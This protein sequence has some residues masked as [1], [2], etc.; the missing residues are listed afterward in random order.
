MSTRLVY[1]YDSSILPWHANPQAIQ[2]ILT[3]LAAKGV[4]CELLNTYNMPEQELIRWRDKALVAAIWRHQKVRQVFGSQKRGGLP[5]LG[6]QVPA[7][8]A[9]EDDEKVPMGVYPHSEKIGQTRTDLT[10]EAYLEELSNS[11]RA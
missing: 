9:Y 10:I 6:K 7:L 11:I 4:R 2:A 3:R 8:L 1:L 5:Y